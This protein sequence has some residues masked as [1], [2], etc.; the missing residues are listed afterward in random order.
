LAELA[1]HIVH[2][3][4]PCHNEKDVLEEEFNSVKN[5]IPIMESQLQTEK[6]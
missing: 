5:G 6:V 2:V 3:I 1:Q 4:E